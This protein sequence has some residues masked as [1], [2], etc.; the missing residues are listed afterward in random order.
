VT[1]KVKPAV[2]GVEKS[3]TIKINAALQQDSI[4]V[5]GSGS[6]SGVRVH[7]CNWKKYSLK[8]FIESSGDQTDAA[9]GLRWAHAAESHGIMSLTRR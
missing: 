5:R 9:D 8:F 3:T 1:L 6:G 2:V 4:V 7:F